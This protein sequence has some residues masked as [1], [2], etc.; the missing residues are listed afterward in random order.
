MKTCFN[1]LRVPSKVGFSFEFRMYLIK[2]CSMFLMILE[3]TSRLNMFYWYI[4]FFQYKNA[5]A[6][7]ISA[8]CILTVKKTWGP[9]PCFDYDLSA[10]AAKCTPIAI[11]GLF[12]EGQRPKSRFQKSDAPLSQKAP[13]EKH[14]S[15]DSH[16]FWRKKWTSIPPKIRQ[17]SENAQIATKSSPPAVQ[18]RRL[19]PCHFLF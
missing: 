6:V 15:K 11:F 14:P 7:C 13:A 4:R 16:V 9:F 3:S 8:G 10:C 1:Q 19:P 2:S 17:M 5:Y 12:L 18:S